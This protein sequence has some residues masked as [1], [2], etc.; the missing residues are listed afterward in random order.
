MRL[1]G[2]GREGKPMPGAG[3]LAASRAPREWEMTL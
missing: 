2:I 3:N 1:P